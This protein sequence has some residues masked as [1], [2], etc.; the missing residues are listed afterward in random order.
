MVCS[1]PSPRPQSSDSEPCASGVT[2]TAAPSQVTD[3]GAPRILAIA[4][5]VGASMV[6]SDVNVSVNAPFAR[7]NA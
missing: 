6:G 3:V 7:S 5:T 4:I 2:V 1:F